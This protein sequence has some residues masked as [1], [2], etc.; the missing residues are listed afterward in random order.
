[1]IFTPMVHVDHGGFHMAT[2]FSLDLV[3]T[4]HYN[5]I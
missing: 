5:H 1:M 3:S 4:D 2:V